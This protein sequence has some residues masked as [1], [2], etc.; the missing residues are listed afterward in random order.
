MMMFISLFY[1]IIP[2]KTTTSY[3]EL[4][5]RKKRVKQLEKLYSDMALQKE[6]QVFVTTLF[7]RK[8]KLTT[9]FYV[10]TH[11]PFNYLYSIFFTGLVELGSTIT[12]VNY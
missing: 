2:R 10:G 1:F 4:E 11:P 3:K 5:A 9:T 7:L 6:L 12:Y 8:K